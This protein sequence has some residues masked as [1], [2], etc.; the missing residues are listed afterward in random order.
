[1]DKKLQKRIIR[2]AS[3]LEKLAAKDVAKLR[4]TYKAAQEKVEKAKADVEKTKSNL[5]D[6]LV[7]SPRS[8]HEA[9]QLRSRYKAAKDRLAKA[10][11][12][13]EKAKSELISALMTTPREQ[14]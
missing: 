11:A 9:P 10:E 8:N 12:A 13:L 3:V 5:T 4:F 14:H 2:V 1:M 7:S 6:K